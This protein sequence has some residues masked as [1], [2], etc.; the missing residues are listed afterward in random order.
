MNRLGCV[1]VA[2]A[3]LTVA[4]MVVSV[5][6]RADV[7][8]SQGPSVRK[9][10]SAGGTSSE[11]RG[12]TKPPS[13]EES[14][15]AEEKR[16]Q[17]EQLVEACKQTPRPPELNAQCNDLARGLATI[18]ADPGQVAR[19]VVGVLQLPGSTPI[20]GPDPKLN[21]IRPGTLV[22]GYPYWLTVPGEATRTA[23]ATAQGLTLQLTGTRARV[24]FDLGD[25][26]R[27]SCATTTPWP[28]GD[29]AVGPNGLPLESPTCGYRYQ[30]PATVTVRA[31]VTW[32]ITWSGAGQTGA[33]DLTHSETVT[34]D[35]IEV[36]AVQR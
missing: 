12:G 13:G 15:Q 28:G 1:A 10:A 36:H 16:R 8:V 18:V 24:D 19:E 20:F 6:A 22:V 25:G 31:T 30:R 4:A 11:P 29:R 21:Q 27:L 34:L 14:R 3:C 2:I 32:H 33:F 17:Y 35:V 9:T 7:D 5:P 23:T 26:S